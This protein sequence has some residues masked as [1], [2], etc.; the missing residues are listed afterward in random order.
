[1]FDG[2]PEKAC[3]TQAGWLMIWTGWANIEVV[4]EQRDYQAA[5]AEI[6]G[7]V[8]SGAGAPRPS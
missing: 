3:W 2:L 5:R 1:V 6:V 4:K 7:R 8:D